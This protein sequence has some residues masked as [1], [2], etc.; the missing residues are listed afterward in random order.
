[1]GNM[2]AGTRAVFAPGAKIGSYGLALTLRE[3]YDL[4]VFEKC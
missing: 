1:M 4:K 2:G 3:R